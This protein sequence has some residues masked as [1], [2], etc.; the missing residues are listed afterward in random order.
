MALSFS[1][2]YIS[3]IRRLF[4]LNLYEAKVWLALLSQ[5]RST[6]S[7]LSD[8]ANIPKSRAYD[9]L[10][11]LE[12]SGFVIKEATKPMSYSAVPPTELL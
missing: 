11:S 7:K 1:E 10:V 4:D 2:E 9:I 3:R 12:N 6:T 8:I 5:G